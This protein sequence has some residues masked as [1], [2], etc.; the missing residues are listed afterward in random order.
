MIHLHTLLP[1]LLS[2]LLYQ[3]ADLQ[4][5]RDINKDAQILDSTSVYISD[6]ASLSPSLQTVANDL[7][8]FQVMASIDLSQSGYT[9]QQRGKH[10]VHTWRFGEGPIKAIH[11]IE[12]AIALDTVVTQ[13]YLENRA[14]TQQR[15]M[16]KFTFRTYAVSTAAAPIKLYYLTEEEQG[17]LEYK[18]DERQVELIYPK[19]KQG[20]SDIM[21]KLKDELDRLVVELSKGGK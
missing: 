7:Q 3:V 15:I 1:V 8:L 12:T 20:L 17:L 4:L 2:F 9:S 6:N 18:I 11:Q 5:A 10:L 19:K 14:P 21:P 16:N 13:R